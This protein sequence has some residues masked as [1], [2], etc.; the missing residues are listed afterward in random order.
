MR[1]RE[2]WTI[3]FIF[4]AIFTAMMCHYAYFVQFG[5]D[6]IIN[7]SHNTR[8]KEL[9]KQVIRGTI[10]AAD[11]TVLAEE[12][13]DSMGREVR[14]YP[15][16]SLFSHVVG[17]ST[18]GTSGLERAFDID[19][20]TSNA[21]VG[22]K[23]QKEMAGVRNYGDS[24]YTSLR[25]DLQMT[26]YQA[27]GSYKGAIIVMEAKTGRILAMVSKPDFDPN[28]VSEN[29]AA[30]SSDE[31]DSP[32]LN[33][34][35]QGLYPPGSTFKIV[36]LYEYIREN[37]DTY[38]AYRYNCTGSITVDDSRIECYHGSV[39]G[40]EDLLGSFANSCNTS[41]TNIGLGL[42]VTQLSDTCDSMLFNRVLPTDLAYSRSRIK[43]SS[44]SDTEDIMQ[45]AIGQGDMLVTPLHMALIT[46][47]ISN[48]GMMMLSQ[49]AVRKTNYQ[50]TLIEEYKPKEYR[51]IMSVEE[52]AVLRDYM[53]EVCNTGTGKKLAGLPYQ[54][55]GK[56]GSAEFGT[57]KGA[58]HS[59]FTGFSNP[60][61]PDI[62]VTVI[63]ENG[64][65]GSESAVPA[66]KR[67]FDVYYGIGG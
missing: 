43:L 49:E 16:G 35:S 9:A 31:G 41:F 21:P 66:A 18:R 64:G 4:L 32:L 54:V 46:E 44:L 51:R 42:D 19:L 12:A 55:A 15:Y 14:N 48:G 25:P 47:A 59:W 23:I 28:T 63:M 3:V 39:H 50:G 8:K 33:R 62:V 11:G 40:E 17:F 57:V 67:I 61:D 60:D 27:L 36:T 5:A 10:Y 7:D 30:I 34:A 45:A 24:I 26:C 58:S 65:S 20:L 52:A 2:I 56:T 6:S 13:L 53:K 38:P 37:P 1:R 29:W 22:E